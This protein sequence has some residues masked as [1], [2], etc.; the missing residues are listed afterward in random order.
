MLRRDGTRRF[1]PRVPHTPQRPAL[2]AAVSLTQD[3]D[4]PS[5]GAARPGLPHPGGDRHSR[6]R[7]PQSPTGTGA[8]RPGVPRPQPALPDPSP[9]RT[10]RGARPAVPDGGA[11]VPAAT[12]RDGRTLLRSLRGPGPWGAH[13]VLEPRMSAAS[14][15]KPHGTLA[16][17][18]SQRGDAPGWRAGWR[19]VPALC[20]YFFTHRVINLCVPGRKAREG[21]G[22]CKAVQ[23]ACPSSG[24]PR[25]SPEADPMKCFPFP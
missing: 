13:A 10:R 4:V 15:E 6:S 21:G 12:G 1:G 18:M 20:I 24:P 11:S 9:T 22:P 17:G 8:V 5:P 7:P 23:P 25:K 16:G 14:G 2:P 19:P 3:G